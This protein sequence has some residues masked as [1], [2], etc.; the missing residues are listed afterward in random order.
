ME[1][2]F[3]HGVQKFATYYF[4]RPV[5]FSYVK[6]TLAHTT[7]ASPNLMEI[8]FIPS[9]GVS[10]FSNGGRIELIFPTL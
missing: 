2:T 9:V 8:S 5:D 6:A 7:A 4:V 1:S 10:S 3:H